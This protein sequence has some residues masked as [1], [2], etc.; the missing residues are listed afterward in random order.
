[1]P[2]SFSQYSILLL[3]FCSSIGFELTN[4]SPQQITLEEGQDAILNCYVNDIYR[5]CTIKHNILKC[6]Y[7]WNRHARMFTYNLDT[8]ECNRDN[9][10]VNQSNFTRCIIQINSVTL[11]ESGE[12]TCELQ[13]WANNRAH[14]S[15]VIGKMMLNILPKTTTTSITTTTTATTTKMKSTY[16]ITATTEFV[17]LI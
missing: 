8:L 16:I 13:Q 3:Q 11:K 12:W 14:A 6:D 5:W 9:L 1:M 15:K 4:V 17:P 10:I 7:E 2:G